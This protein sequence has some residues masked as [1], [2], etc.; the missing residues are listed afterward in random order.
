MQIIW[1]LCQINISLIGSGCSIFKKRKTSAFLFD[2][3]YI[4][5]YQNRRLNHYFSGL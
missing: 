5:I 2:N 3:L 1:E 4:Q